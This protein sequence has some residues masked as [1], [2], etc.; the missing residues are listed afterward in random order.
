MVGKKACQPY[1]SAYNN[2]KVIL[3]GCES[4]ME[5]YYKAVTLSLC[6]LSEF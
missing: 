5:P 4:F 3:E 1:L 6:L 2:I